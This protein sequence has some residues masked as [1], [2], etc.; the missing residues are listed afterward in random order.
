MLPQ[1]Q[2]HDTQALLQ[3]WAVVAE[4]AALHATTLAV[5]DGVPILALETAAA[6]AREPAIYLSA[7]VHGDEPAPPWALLHWAEK[8][9]RKLQRSSFLILPCLNPTGLTHN[10]RVDHRALDLNRLFHDTT[11]AICG[12]W[13]RWI[14][15]RP[16][17]AA[18]CL[19]EDYDAQG[20]YV[21]ELSRRR[22]AISHAILKRCRPIPLDPRR[23]IDGSRASAG[24]IRR[25]NIPTHLPGMPEAIE[26]YLR[27]CPLT[28]TFETPSEFSLD[29]R[30]AAHLRFIHSTLTEVPT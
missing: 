19:H 9:L 26:L 5:A 16:M 24:I 2:A 12:P 28:L 1:H 4:K 15:A 23:S 22:S 27:G 30:I 10:T 18:L 11:D 25:K 7:G 20:I 21:Y 14:R 3:R 29:A 17:H 13:Q 8:N 6:Q